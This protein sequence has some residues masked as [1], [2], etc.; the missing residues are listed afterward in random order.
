M[1]HINAFDIP[2]RKGGSGPKYLF[3]GPRI[4]WGVLKF[5][6]GEKLGLHK[7]A[8]V[9]ETFF[10]T[11]GTPLM[12]VD[13]KEHRVRVGDAFRLEPGDVHNIINDTG[14]SIEAVFIKSIYKPDD[15][16]DVA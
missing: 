15:K 5:N 7:H 6:P 1:E 12:I 8:E 2:F 14:E 11:K 13:G 4:D 10:F 3:R 16:I 9:E